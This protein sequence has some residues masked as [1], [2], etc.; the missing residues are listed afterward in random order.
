MDRL[1]NASVRLIY[2]D[3]RGQQFMASHIADRG[4][5]WWDERKPDEYSLW[6]SKIRLGED[7]FNEIIQHPVPLDMNILTALKRSRPGPRSLPLAQLPHLRAARSAAA[8]LAD[9][10]PPVRNGTGQG[11]Q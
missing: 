7:L 5:F 2:E 3:E 6:N 1:F 9:A 10:L 11:G 8:L 4:E